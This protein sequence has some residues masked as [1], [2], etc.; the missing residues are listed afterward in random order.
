MQLLE[1]MALEEFDQSS[2][3][4]EQCM[5]CAMEFDSVLEGVEIPN[6]F[7]K[8]VKKLADTFSKLIGKDK[9][10]ANKSLKKLEVKLGKKPA[11]FYRFGERKMGD[12]PAESLH[13][14]VKSRGYKCSVNI[15]KDNR[16]ENRYYLKAIPGGYVNLI[17]ATSIPG[18]KWGD[19]ESYVIAK[20]V[21]ESKVTPEGLKMFK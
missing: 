6:E 8:E 19:N 20:F 1:Q 13:G 10:E 14:K 15:D 11:K 5:E 7:V 4:A 9:A 16:A 18:N 2:A 21:E 12:V 3:V 17:V